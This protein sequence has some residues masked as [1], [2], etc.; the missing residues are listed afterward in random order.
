MK[1][2][3]HTCC[4]PCSIYCIDELKK[5]KINITSF[6][7]NPNIHPYTEYKSRLDTLKKHCELIQLPLEIVDEYGLRKFTINVINDLENRCDYCYNERLKATAE[8]AYNN[9]YDTFSTTLLISPYQNHEK[10]K[11]IGKKI[12]K[13]IGI[14]FLY[15]DFREGFRKGQNRARELEIYMQKYCGCVFSEEDR[16]LKKRDI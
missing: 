12:S 10:I 16:Y 11:E 5:D 6:W 7:Y 13:E 4:A 9:G 15:K 3:L 2:L 8:Y 1:L 14:D